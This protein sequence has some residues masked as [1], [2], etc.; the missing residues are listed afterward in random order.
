M[1]CSSERR[2][3]LPLCLTRTLSRPP[4]QKRAL[5]GRDR[6][7]SPALRERGLSLPRSQWDREEGQES[8]PEAAKE[9]AQYRAPRSKTR[10]ACSRPRTLLRRCG[11]ERVSRNAKQRVGRRGLQGSQ[12]SRG[13]RQAA[14]H[15]CRSTGTREEAARLDPPPL[16]PPV[17]PSRQTPRILRPQAVCTTKHAGGEGGTVQQQRVGGITALELRGRHVHA[18]AGP[19]LD[20]DRD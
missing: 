17:E 13:G 12:E 14:R 10:P 19:C 3:S 8:P 7:V 9:N 18:R 4:G 1:N 16:A 11:S 20:D 5:S 6:S 2:G 15:A